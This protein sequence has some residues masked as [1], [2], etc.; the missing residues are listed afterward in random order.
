M[1]LGIA[2][3]ASITAIAILVGLAWKTA[4]K[5][6]NKWIPVVCG[7][8]GLILGIVAYLI[9]VP[10]F[11]ANDI[12]TAGAVGV[13]SGFAATGIHQVKKEL[14]DEDENEVADE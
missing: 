5:L 4:T 13:A 7:S 11:P 2:S 8:V 1:G 6:D 14:V 3:V 12:I 9:H 10:E